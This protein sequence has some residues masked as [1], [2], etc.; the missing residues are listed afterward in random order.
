MVLRPCSF[1]FRESVGSVGH[2]EPEKWPK[3][4]PSVNLGSTRPSPYFVSFPCQ[5]NGT[6]DT[7]SLPPLSWVLCLMLHSWLVSPHAQHSGFSGYC[8]TNNP[9][10]QVFLLP[11]QCA[12][13]ISVN[14]K[15]STVRLPLA[16]STWEHLGSQ[17]LLLIIHCAKLV[18]SSKFSMCVLQFDF[19][20]GYHYHQRDWGMAAFS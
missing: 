8:N 5:Q 20:C 15:P 4:H 1:R 10:V 16:L 13:F 7:F 2:S 9:Q 19:N 3:T 14:H 6:A 11:P 17:I 12:A 18:Q